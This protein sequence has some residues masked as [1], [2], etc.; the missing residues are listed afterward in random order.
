VKHQPPDPT[1]PL[2]AAK[3]SGIIDAMKTTVPEV[4]GETFDPAQDGERLGDQYR[5]VRDF[6]ADGAWHSLAAIEEATGAPQASASA[7]LRDMRRDGWSVD[8]MRVP[9][10]NG[11]WLYRANRLDTPPASR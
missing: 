1:P 6:M 4:K 10:G 5:A 7:R 8:R 11:L 9:G 2:F 3:L